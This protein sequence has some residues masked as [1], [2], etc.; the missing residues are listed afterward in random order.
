MNAN[1]RLTYVKGWGGGVN[2][3]L[4]VSARIGLSS[5]NSPVRFH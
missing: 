1:L 5:S 4:R 2:A 3:N